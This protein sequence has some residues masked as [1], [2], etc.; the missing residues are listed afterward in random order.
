M[1]FS[2]IFPF[3][4]TLGWDEIAES[5][6]AMITPDR[7]AQ[8]LVPITKLAKFFLAANCIEG[9]KTVGDCISSFFVEIDSNLARKS[10][11]CDVE[12]FVDM[13]VAL[14]SN[15]ESSSRKRITSFF[16][17][18][19]NLRP[20]L[21]CHLLLNFESQHGSR[22]KT[23]HSWQFIYRDVCAIF[24]D[25]SNTCSPPLKCMDVDFMK[26][27]EIWLSDLAEEAKLRPE[28]QESIKPNDDATDPVLEQMVTVS[29]SSKSNIPSVELNPDGD[30]STTDWVD[31]SDALAATKSN[32]LAA[33]ESETKSFSGIVSSNDWCGKTNSLTMDLK[34]KDSASCMSKSVDDWDACADSWTS[35]NKKTGN[36]KKTVT[37]G[38]QSSW[39]VP[40]KM[41]SNKSIAPSDD[42][43]SWSS[44]SNSTTSKSNVVSTSGLNDDWST[45]TDAWA[46]SKGTTT[47]SSQSDPWGSTETVKNS[48]TGGYNPSRGG[49]GGARTPLRPCFKVIVLSNL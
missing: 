41:P 30:A 17:L 13:L 35:G 27:I 24:S 19:S 40:C 31:A 3:Y 14:E 37:N 22:L 38:D 32:K 16:L 9:A 49:R 10:K 25:S 26:T 7:L 11:C 44:T 48:W 20:S 1:L 15:P 2:L 42:W 23:I 6:K 46:S 18:F 4:L 29:V 28:L 45:S 39:D 47:G 33:A 21:Q 5:I 43:N 34:V 36:E 12:A 8:Q